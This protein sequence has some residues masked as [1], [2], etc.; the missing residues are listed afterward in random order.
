[1]P[2]SGLSNGTLRPLKEDDL[3]TVLSW[4]NHPDIRRYML[5]QHE[6][7][8]IEHSQWFAAA[9]NDVAKHLLVF[10][11]EG[12][13]SGFVHFSLVTSGLV[14]DWGFYPVKIVNTDR[15]LLAVSAK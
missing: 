12:N 6:I 9:S 1:M 11:L 5:T 7:S 8:L 4:R 3:A 13:P 10:E 14:A 2:D 15:N